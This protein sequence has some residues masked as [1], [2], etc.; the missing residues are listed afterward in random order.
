MAA[1]FGAGT[2]PIVYS[3]TPSLGKFP[4]KSRTL[5][6]PLGLHASQINRSVPTPKS[7]VPL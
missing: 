4:L 7:S 1:V 3:I 6:E 2:S 5:F